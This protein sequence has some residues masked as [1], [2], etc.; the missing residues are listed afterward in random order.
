[1]A[2]Q[3]DTLYH[4]RYN[5][6]SY[7]PF[8]LVRVWTSGAMYIDGYKLFG[9]PSIYNN[10]PDGG[11]HTHTHTHSFP[12]VILGI[13]PYIPIG[14]YHSFGAILLFTWRNDDTYRRY[15][16]I[17]IYIVWYI[18]TTS[19]YIERKKEEKSCTL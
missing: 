2:F 9:V 15:M 3:T 7:E 11:A 6:N 10:Q 12:G 14:Y 8:S 19:M 18:R 17:Y 16:H 5:L 1:M 4:C 13:F